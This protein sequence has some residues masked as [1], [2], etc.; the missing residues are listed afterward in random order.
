MTSLLFLLLVTAMVQVLLLPIVVGATGVF[1]DKA[2]DVAVCKAKNCNDI[3]LQNKK[4]QK[5]ICKENKE[6][7]SSCPQTC[8]D[9]SV[10][11]NMCPSKIT[12]SN[13]EK[14][15]SDKYQHNRQCNYDYRYTGCTWDELQCTSQKGYTCD[16]ESSTWNLTTTN[17]E[18]CENPPKDLPVHE[19]C[20][21]CSDMPAEGCPKTKPTNQEDCS[22]FE[23][24]LW[25]SY[26]FILCTRNQ[27]F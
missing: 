19:V 21:P 16:Y 9:V 1:Q 27:L 3:R 17:I 22:N 24:D 25:C 15:C 13:F 23:T 8:D 4:K 14:D 18:V 10:F 6:V 11:K 5:K 20:V 26:N 2:G 7:R 12:S